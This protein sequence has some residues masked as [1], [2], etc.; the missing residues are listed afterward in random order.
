MVI[1]S[2]CGRAVCRPCEPASGGAS[3]RPFIRL[4]RDRELRAPVYFRR[5]AMAT[6]SIGL[7]RREI[8]NW[9]ADTIFGFDG[10]ILD[11]RGVAVTIGDEDI[12]DAFGDDGSF[13]WLSD[14]VRF[15]ERPPRQRPQ[16]RVLARLRLIDLAFRIAKPDVARHFGR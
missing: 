3:G 15:A 4:A 14:F 5:L 6:A 10:E 13:R 11:E 1:C 12:D 9:L 8:P 16:F 2:K 7:S